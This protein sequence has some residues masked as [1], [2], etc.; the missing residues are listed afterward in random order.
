MRYGSDTSQGLADYAF[1]CLVYREIGM[2]SP[3]HA[4]HISTRCCSRSLTPARANIR[5]VE[6]SAGAVESSWFIAVLRS[7]RRRDG[8]PVW[9]LECSASIGS[10]DPPHLTRTR[11][12]GVS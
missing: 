2:S 12:I 8:D 9:D 11:G 7:S 6:P 10:V 4:F 3:F 1:R 5:D